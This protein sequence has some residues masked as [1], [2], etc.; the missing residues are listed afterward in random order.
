ME[1]L[2]LESCHSILKA[3]KTTTEIAL[4][5]FDALDPVSLDFMLGRW[6]GSGLQTN[7][8]MDGL[9]EASNWYG[10]ELSILRMSTP[11]YF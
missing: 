8:P 5:L 6:Q 10:K 9:L 1:T 2:E 4:Q 7:H 3:G 11:C